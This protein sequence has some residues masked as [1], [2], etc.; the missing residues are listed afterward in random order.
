[1]R[2][3]TSRFTRRFLSTRAVTTRHLPVAVGASAVAL[4]VAAPAIAGHDKV[5]V[6]GPLTAYSPAV[7]EGAKGRVKAIYDA[8]GSTFVRLRVR[9][10]LPNTEYG[11]HAHVNVCGPTGADA[12]PHFQHVV[13]PVSPSTNPE[14]ANAENEIWLDLTTDAQGRGL[15]EAEVD[16]QFSPDRRAKS[17]IIHEEHTHTGQHDAGTAGARLACLTVPF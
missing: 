8:D 17:V 14:Y 13:D 15:A 10:L 5:M 11:A 1:M 16:W 3:P 9:G 12:G 7:P 4:F 2:K 6:E